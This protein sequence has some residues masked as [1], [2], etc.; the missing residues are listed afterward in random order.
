MGRRQAKGGGLFQARIL[1]LPGFPV[2]SDWHLYLIRTRHGA[3]YTGIATDPRRR[4]SEHEG[5]GGKGSKYLRSK[6]PLELVYRANIGSRGLALRA[7]ERIK[8]LSKRRKEELVEAN[9]RR[10]K[11]LKTLALEDN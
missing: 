5:A 8:R 7:E 1:R 11:L 3:L 4:I 9:P 2:M 10:A 6:G